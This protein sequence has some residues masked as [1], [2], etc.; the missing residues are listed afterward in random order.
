[1]PSDSLQVVLTYRGVWLQ[2]PVQGFWPNLNAST[3]YWAVVAPS[4]PT[5]LG[6]TAQYPWNGVFWCGIDITVTAVPAGA[7]LDS[8]LFTARELR[9]QRYKGD[10]QFAA[11]TAAGV[12]F[13]ANTNN[14]GDVATQYA[15]RYLNFW[16]ANSAIRYGIQVRRWGGRG[17]KKGG[18]HHS[19]ATERSV[20]SG[21]RMA[22]QAGYCADT[23]PVQAVQR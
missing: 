10:A 8:P 23:M 17:V 7:G 5:Q 22:T 3:Y 4:D 9:S 12:G 18:G 21:G 2:V 20:R 11:S 6:F 16:T 19:V 14:W 13:V 1:M 15:A